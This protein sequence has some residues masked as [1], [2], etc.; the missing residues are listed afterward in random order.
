MTLRSGPREPSPAPPEP[1][2]TEPI[3]P[4]MPAG[5]PVPEDMPTPTPHPTGPPAP[6]ACGLARTVENRTTGATP[7]DDSVT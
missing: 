5:G 1:G 3:P 4:E 6:V 2:K 7:A